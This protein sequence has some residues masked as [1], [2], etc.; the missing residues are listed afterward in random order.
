MLKKP[1]HWFAAH[2]E[3]RRFHADLVSIHDA[4]ENAWITNTILREQNIDQVHLGRLN[5]F[6]DTQQDTDLFKGQFTLALLYA[7]SDEGT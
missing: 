4:N 5:H 3:C 1:R 7:C 6:E 2:E